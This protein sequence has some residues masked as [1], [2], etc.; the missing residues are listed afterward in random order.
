[1]VSVVRV[2][3]DRPGGKTCGTFP[4]HPNG[5][6]L[7]RGNAHDAEHEAFSLSELRWNQPHNRLSRRAGMKR[8][9][10]VVVVGDVV[11]K[12][13]DFT[14]AKLSH[15][16]VSWS[17]WGC[18]MHISPHVADL[19]AP[20]VAGCRVG[21]RVSPARRVVLCPVRSVGFQRAVRV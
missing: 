11:L 12:G 16:Y 8:S 14:G 4:H 5:F 18:I 17:W 21:G 19:L 7:T 9:E 15:A 13:G 3:D 6:A 1:M 10:L 20:V 2:G